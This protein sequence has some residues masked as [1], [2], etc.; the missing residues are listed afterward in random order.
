MNLDDHHKLVILGK[1]P[2]YPAGGMFIWTTLQGK[3][4]VGKIMAAADEDLSALKGCNTM[5][6]K[7]VREAKVHLQ[8][9]LGETNLQKDIRTKS[10]I[11]FKLFGPK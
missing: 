5:I 10:Y 11:I 4:G 8:K 6:D 7:I 1:N 9:I 3:D 2:A